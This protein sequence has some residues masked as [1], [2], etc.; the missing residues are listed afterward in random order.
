MRLGSRLLL[1]FTIL[2]LTFTL[3][4]FGVISV[5]IYRTPAFALGLG[6]FHTQ[7]NDG[8]LVT[9]SNVVLV[10]AGLVLWLLHRRIGAWILLFYSAFWTANFGWAVL[11]IVPT[12]V[13][14]RVVVCSGGTCDS[15]PIAVAV[16]AGFTLCGVWSLLQVLHRR[17]P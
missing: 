1:C 16:V 5:L 12:I 11:K 7:G 15:L 6:W 2:W 9:I 13:R 3:V 17:V 10:L 14:H 8:L 4:F